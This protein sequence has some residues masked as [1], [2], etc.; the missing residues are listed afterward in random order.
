MPYSTRPTS[1][2]SVS[3]TWGTGD[4]TRDRYNFYVTV[5]A[6]KQKAIPT[7]NRPDYL[8]TSNLEFMGLPDTRPGNPPLG[9]GTSS[10]L[11][12]VRPVAGNDL[13]GPL[14]GPYQSL[15]GACEPK[16]QSDGFCKWDPKDWQN[17]QNE[18]EKYNIF[19]RGAYN[20]TP[21]IQGYTELSYF[22]SKFNGPVSP[23]PLRATWPDV[24]GTTVISSLNTIYMPVGHPDNPF[25]AQGQAAYFPPP[26]TDGGWIRLGGIFLQRR[27]GKSRKGLCHRN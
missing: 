2:R 9:W 26:D 22:R 19:A 1:H 21:D 17:V 23:T 14:L 18:L 11:G 7:S 27:S 4:I 3:A 16:N 24:Q 5:D 12:N 13:T 25:S 15:P 8:G 6:Q 20:F 10:P